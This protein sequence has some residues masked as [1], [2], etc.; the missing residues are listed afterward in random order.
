[1]KNK[2]KASKKVQCLCIDS[3]ESTYTS[4]RFKSNVVGHQMLQEGDVSERN[5]NDVDA[6]G[7]GYSVPMG[8]TLQS[9]VENCLTP[10]QICFSENNEVTTPDG[11]DFAVNV[12]LLF[13]SLRWLFSYSCTPT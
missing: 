2:N 11:L 1:M 6:T 3:C 10:P 9:G 4:K 5:L 8:K 13:V 12:S 7:S